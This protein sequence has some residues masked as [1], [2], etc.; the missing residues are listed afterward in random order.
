MASFKQ[1]ESGMWYFIID[2]GEDPITKKRRQKTISKGTNG[3]SFETERDARRAADKMQDDI[4]RG[5]KFES[6][7]LVELMNHFLDKVVKDSVSDVTYE[8]QKATTNKHILPYLGQKKIEKVTDS[9]IEDL[10]EQLEEKGVQRGTIRNISIVLS[11]FFKHCMK[12]RHIVD[13]PMKLVDTPSYKPN[14]KNIWTHDQV[15]FFLEHTKEENFLPLY[16]LAADTGM[17]RGELKGLS[18]PFVNLDNKTV[19]I[20]KALKYTRSKGKHIG[21]PKTENSKRTIS[22]SD[23]AVNALRS[24]KERQMKGVEIVF[25]NF[26]DH[27]SIGQANHQ[28]VL[29]AKELKMPHMTLHGLRHYHATDLL[30]NGFSVAQVAERLGDTKETIMRTYAHAIPNSQKQISDFLDRRN[31]AITVDNSTKLLT[32]AGNIVDM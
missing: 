15:M 31:A 12:K 24:Q 26:G 2:V 10:Y 21:S 27:Y 11:K 16:V 32:N 6:P 19:T 4:D 22:I 30:S 20:I 1:R 7:R 23:M 14:P 18:W 25:D 13:N 5:M 3:R 29:S 17:R 8:D 9:D 28:F